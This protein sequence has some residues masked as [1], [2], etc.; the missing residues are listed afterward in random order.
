MT[1]KLQIVKMDLEGIVCKRRDGLKKSASR[2]GLILSC[3]VA[4][5]HIHSKEVP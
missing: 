3:R 5:R 2:E 1:V 4:T